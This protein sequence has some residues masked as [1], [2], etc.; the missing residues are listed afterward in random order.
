MSG[1]IPDPSGATDTD[2]IHVNVDGEIDGLTE[3]SIPVIGDLVVIESAADSFAKRKVQIGN[4][5]GGGSGTAFRGA[6]TIDDPDT[7]VVVN[8]NLGTTPGAGELQA[9]PVD[10]TDGWLDGAACAKFGISDIGSAT[11][12]I[13]VDAAPGTGKHATFH[14]LYV[15][16]DPAP[17]FDPTTVSGLVV[18][19]DASQLTGLSDTDP[20]AS[21]P[22]L[23]TT[24]SEAFAQASGGNQPLYRTGIQNGLPGVRFDGTNDHLDGTVSRTL[25]PVTI[26]AAVRGIDYDLQFIVGNVSGNNA[27]ILRS[28]GQKFQLDREGSTT[29]ATNTTALTNDTPYL[30][31]VT[32]SGAD[33]FAWGLDGSADGSGSSAQG[34]AAAPICIGARDS[35]SLFFNGYIHEIL[36]WDNV[37]ASGDLAAVR[38]SLLAKWAI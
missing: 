22:N 6:A 16:A 29:F 33:A 21:W 18:W 37:I 32:Y 14:W 23:I 28:N 30:V 31:D 34:I 17:S 4:L 7:D 10:D 20:V 8:H 27:L 12:K 36:I 5:P 11:F 19:L 15:A 35:G 38:D 24:D 1:W 9:T 3:K 13:N 25:K 2:A 26:V